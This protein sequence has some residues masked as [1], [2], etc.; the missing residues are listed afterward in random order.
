MTC[1]FLPATTNEISLRIKK[2]TQI[3]E[4]KNIPEFSIKNVD[5]NTIDIQPAFLEQKRILYCS[6]TRMATVSSV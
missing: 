4:N 2:A 6:Q 3:R 5:L 1:F